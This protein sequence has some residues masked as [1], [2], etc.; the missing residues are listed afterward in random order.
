MAARE[1]KVKIM[2][3][4]VNSLLRRTHLKNK[5]RKECHIGEEVKVN[6]M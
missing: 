2:R 5:G 4:T 6:R 3:A 1:N